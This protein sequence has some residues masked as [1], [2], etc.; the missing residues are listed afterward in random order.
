MGAGLRCESIERSR[1]VRSGAATTCS[2][3][4]GLDRDAPSGV[5]ARPA[6][7]ARTVRPN[8]GR[9]GDRI[10][11]SV[12]ASQR[13]CPLRIPGAVRRRSVTRRIPLYGFGAG[14]A[15]PQGAGPGEGRVGSAGPRESAYLLLPSKCCV[16]R[17]GVDV[18]ELGDGLR[19]IDVDSI[20]HGAAVAATG[21]GV[22][23][24][25]Y[26]LWAT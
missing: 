26:L 23:H 19:E 2:A 10:A 12:V 20:A 11:S 22:G 1:S 21:M 16:E 3:S 7:A 6:Q 13:T 18:I 24:G 17:R 14:Q 25:K 9:R 4:P 15:A 5:G 8:A